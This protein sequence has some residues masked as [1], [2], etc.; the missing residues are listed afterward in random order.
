MKYPYITFHYN[1]IGRGKLRIHKNVDNLLT[2]D[3]RPGSINTL[4]ELA[5][6]IKSGKW[7]VKTPHEPTEEKAMIIGDGKGW[8]TRLYTKD[9]EYT[10][11]LIHPDGN[12]PGSLGCIVTP[13]MAY[14]VR[15]FIDNILKDVDEIPVYINIKPEK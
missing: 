7:I 15:D 12:K 3:A 13:T 14:N 2:V 10:H 6:V 11:Y 4:G 9:G 1:D 5:N 8:K